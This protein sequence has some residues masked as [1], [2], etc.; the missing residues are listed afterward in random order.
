MEKPPLTSSATAAISTQPSPEAYA[1]AVV[2]LLLDHWSTGV[3]ELFRPNGPENLAQVYDEPAAM[4]RLIR[5]LEWFI[6]SRAEP[7][8]LWQQLRD[9]CPPPD[10][11]A[12]VFKGGE[13][14]YSCQDCAL[15]G[16]CVLCVDC[17][18]HR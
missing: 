5:P 1:R 15:D 14:V 12:K 4:D 11:C 8:E 6:T 2:A 3:P 7:A 18:K 17:F 13:P 10:L 16:T 9:I